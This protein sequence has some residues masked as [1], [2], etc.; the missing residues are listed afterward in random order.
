[1]PTGR[2]PVPEPL[3]EHSDSVGPP[4]GA[5]PEAMKA[6]TLTSARV[7]LALDGMN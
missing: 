7:R 2:S 3:R 6:P 4:G 1:M 5:H